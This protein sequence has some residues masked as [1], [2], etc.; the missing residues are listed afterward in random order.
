MPVAFFALRFF[1]V[2]NCQGCTVLQACQAVF[3]LVHEFGFAFCYNDI[4]C[5]AD[6]FADPASRARGRHRKKPV[7]VFVR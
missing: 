4:I 3:T 6:F 5:G 1:L 7:A 2:V